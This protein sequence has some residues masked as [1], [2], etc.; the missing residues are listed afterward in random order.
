M[1]D[2]DDWGESVQNSLRARI[3]L[4][5][6]VRD[7]RN[8]YEQGQWDFCRALTQ[9][10]AND[11]PVYV[12]LHSRLHWP[13]SAWCLAHNLGV[14]AA[15]R[16]ANANGWWDGTGYH[17]DEVQLVHR[18]GYAKPGITLTGGTP[19]PACLNVVAA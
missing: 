12:A 8:D 13:Y 19:T 3:G 14:A 15:L 2:L 16:V 9:E 1:R 10:V 11:E 5:S 6:R 4:R 18:K 17:R 7:W